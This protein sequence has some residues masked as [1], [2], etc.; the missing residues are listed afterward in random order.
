MSTLIRRSST[1]STACSSRNRT[2]FGGGGSQGLRTLMA[3]RNDIC[4]SGRHVRSWG[5]GDVPAWVRESSSV[6]TTKTKS[7]EDKQRWRGNT[8][9]TLIELL[10]VIAIIA[11]LAALLLPA[12]ARAK[13]KAVRIMCTS[14]L[15]QWG[16]ALSMY[17]GDNRESLPDN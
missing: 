4:G 10:V 9:F 6:I 7:L 16:V 3:I 15:K 2:A 5:W 8:G 12:L 11:I 14:N 17:G 13:E 1:Y